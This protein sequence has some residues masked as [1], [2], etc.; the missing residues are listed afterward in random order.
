MKKI[1]YADDND[2]RKINW[3]G[4]IQS[5]QP[6]TRVWRYLVDNRTHYYIGYNI[7]LLGKSDVDLTEFSVAISEKQQQKYNFQI[8]DSIKGT[9]WTKMYPKR[10][11]ADFYRAGSFRI[12]ERNHRLIESTAPWI[13]VVPTM[14]VLDER[15][16]RMLSKSRWK[17]KCFPCYYASM[18]NVEIIWDFDKDIKRYRFESFCYGPKSCKYFDPGPARSVPYKGMGSVLDTGWLDKMY[19]RSRDED[20]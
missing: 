8:G 20:E 14:D 11:F 4:I 13:G 6:R 7:F 3:Q 1:R 16:G 5:I 19:T 12:L 10:E 2:C 9:A 15:G 17:R 18:A